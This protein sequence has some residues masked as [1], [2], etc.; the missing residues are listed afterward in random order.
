MWDDFF[1]FFFF[2][3]SII[4]L[5]PSC[6]SRNSSPLSARVCRP[7]YSA[8]F[9]RFNTRKP[10]QDNLCPHSASL[11]HGS[12]RRSQLLQC[13]K[14]NSRPFTYS[15]LGDE[16]GREERGGGSKVNMQYLENWEEETRD[17]K[18]SHFRWRRPFARPP[19]PKLASELRWLAHTNLGYLL[20]FLLL[21]Y[22]FSLG[23][24]RR[25]PCV[26]TGATLPFCSGIMD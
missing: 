8:S 23:F 20:H 15:V 5:C 9:R 24:N 18:C 25:G 3:N 21:P 26:R 10:R 16:R 4:Y 2:F 22:R 19:F 12:S 1:S 13:K 14:I 17:V 6:G 11:P 7:D